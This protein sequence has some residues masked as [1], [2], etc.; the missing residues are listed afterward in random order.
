[1]EVNIQSA[2]AHQAKRKNE[3]EL[4]QKKN[5]RSVGVGMR[6]VGGSSTGEWAVVVGV[7]KKVPESELVS[8]DLVPPQV[9]GVKTDVQE[10]GNIVPEILMEEEPQFSRQG[11][12]RPILQG[13]SVAHQ[14]VTAGTIGW[15]YEAG[16]GTVLVGSNNHVLADI[17][18]GTQG[19][20][21]LQPGPADG[22]TSSDQVGTL[23]WYV[24]VEN[25]VDVDLALANSLSV[26]YDN[27]LA[28]ADLPIGAV[29]DSL[30]VGDT[31]EKTGRT[32]GVTQGE[33]Q[34]LDVSVNVN[35]GGS[36]GTVTI[37]GCILTSDMS[38]GG[39]SGSPVYKRVGGEA[40]PVGRLFGGSSSVTV[41]HNIDNELNHIT[42]QFPN[43]SMITDG[44]GGDGDPTANVTLTLVRETS[45][46]GNIGVQVNDDSGNSVGS[47][48]VTITGDA[49]RTGM[50]DSNGQAS[51]TVPVG[52]YTVEANKTGYQGD[53]V[54][55]T[56]GDFS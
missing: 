17:N 14:A 24:P 2:F 36:L 6:E 29:A 25:N 10:V 35:Y 46:T 19:D 3:K 21:V 28:G 51:F 47:A 18:Q 39:D 42:A 43:A 27:T 41:H 32:T 48:N 13:V 7:S 9:D 55:V 8:Y 34:Q 53:S 38:E 20:P 16:D 4:L 31:V 40:R 11:R 50:T 56:A 5:V 12:N 23:E 1:M 33:V 15:S 54:Q 44:E 22:G 30:S 26:G 37:T 45:D 52:E 49:S